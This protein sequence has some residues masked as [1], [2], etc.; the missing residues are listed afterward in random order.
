M[1]VNYEFEL[2]I[3]NCKSHKNNNIIACTDV[4]SINKAKQKVI[5]KSGQDRFLYMVTQMDLTF[6]TQTS[7]IESIAQQSCSFVM[8]S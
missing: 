4:D 7:P 1:T 8:H 6:T 5:H 2:K 3:F